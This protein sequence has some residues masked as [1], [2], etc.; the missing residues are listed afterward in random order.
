[1]PCSRP[2]GHPSHVPP[3]KKSVNAAPSQ[4]CLHVRELWTPWIANCANPFRNPYAATVVWRA[5][6]PVGLFF[7]RILRSG[8]R[9]CAFIRTQSS[10]RHESRRA[11]RSKNSPS[12]WHPCP[13]VPRGKQGESRFPPLPR[14]IY[15]RQL[16]PSATRNCGP[17]TS[18]WRPSPKILLPDF[19]GTQT[20]TPSRTNVTAS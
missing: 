18:V 5:Y 15:V 3:R 4:R 1:M 20:Q 2:P 11:C 10:P 19:R 13:P 12:K 9:N 6:K 14:T 17:S 8:R 16:D 7:W